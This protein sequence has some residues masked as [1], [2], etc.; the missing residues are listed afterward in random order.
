MNVLD[1]I[2]RLIGGI[3]KLRELSQK[4][5]NAEMHDLIADLMLQGAELKMKTAELQSENL[6]LRRSMDELR[7]KVDIRSKVEFRDGLYYLAQPIHGYGEGPFGPT[8]FD[9]DGLL[10]S[11]T[12]RFRTSYGIDLRSK[13]R[14]HAGWQCGRCANKRRQ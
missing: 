3:K 12:K 5:K 11:L 10:I 7:Q 6:E 14:R 2:D 13:V 8:C 4:L 9:E 1:A